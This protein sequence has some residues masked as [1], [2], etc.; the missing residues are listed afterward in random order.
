MGIV[1]LLTVA[2]RSGETEHPFCAAECCQGCVYPEAPHGV[3]L[4]QLLQRL[5][6][7]ARLSAG[8]VFGLGRPC[9]MTRFLRGWADQRLA[10]RYWRK[11]L[12]RST[13]LVRSRLEDND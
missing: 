2:R 6:S 5:V 10:T 3:V 9:D 12:R 7:P 8:P 11:W 13:T 4:L 1:Q